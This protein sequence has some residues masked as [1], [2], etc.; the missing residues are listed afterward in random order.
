MIHFL[1]VLIFAFSSLR[2]EAALQ[3]AALFSRPS[4]VEFLTEINTRYE[5]SFF[6]KSADEQIQTSNAV[7]RYYKLF[8]LKRLF[9]DLEKNGKNFDQYELADFVYRLDRLAFAD[10]VLQNP[11]LSGKL[12]RLELEALSQARRS[13][14]SQGLIKYLALDTKRPGFWKKFGYY[15][16][17]TLSWK[18]WRWPRAW[19]IMPKLV[20]T[21][22]P[23]E[24]AEKI[25]LE[26]L[27]RH[28]SEVD[29]YLPALASR[30][31]FNSFSKIYNT[32]VLT[33]MLT[34]VP[35]MTHDFYQEQVKLGE[36]NAAQM[37]S[38]LVKTTEEMAG[39]NY[40]LEKE[41]GAL[42]KYIQAYSQKYGA[43]PTEQQI[44]AARI[45]IRSKIE[46]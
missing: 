21:S 43:A 39:I 17:Q 26:G 12:S 45:L 19:L 8:K 11:Q 13:V 22:L 1:V 31:Y 41:Q 40:R 27:D 16:G 15:F 14:L 33:S 7:A 35:Y 2:S 4:A 44:E 23:P 36:Q 30:S 10:V 18:Y 9:K 24:L 25:L 34:V 3:C 6:S 42:D 29:K 20:G 37:L 38:P 28:R 46:S 5:H 32:L